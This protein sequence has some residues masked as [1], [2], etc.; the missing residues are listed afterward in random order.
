L[1]YIAILLPSTTE[2]QHRLREGAGEKSKVFLEGIQI[3]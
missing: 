3:K 1:R 2:H